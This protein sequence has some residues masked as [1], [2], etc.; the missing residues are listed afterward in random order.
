MAGAKIVL[1]QMV[2][3]ETLHANDNLAFDDVTE[4]RKTI[5]ALQYLSIMRPDIA[6]IFGRLD[7]RY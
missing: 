4:Y 6:S 3:K 5:G 1:T 2:T 7:L